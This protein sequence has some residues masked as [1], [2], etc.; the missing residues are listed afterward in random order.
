MKRTFMHRILLYIL[1]IILIVTMSNM[2]CFGATKTGTDYKI[3]SA[4]VPE[5]AIYINWGVNFSIS[6]TYTTTTDSYKLTKLETTA[7]IDP[8]RAADVG[9]GEIIASIEETIDH[10]ASSVNRNLNSSFW[11]NGVGIW[12]LTAYV[13]YH[14]YGSPNKTFRSQAR[15]TGH[16]TFVYVDGIVHNPNHSYTFNITP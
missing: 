4:S 2:V 16:F 7:H 12:P 1:S 8:A 14:K 11:S 15:E 5:V 6:G 13:Y 10:A 9:N 3:F